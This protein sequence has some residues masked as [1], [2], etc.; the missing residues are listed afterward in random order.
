MEQ[1]QLILVSQLD[2]RLGEQGVTKLDD[3]T[4]T[5]D[6]TFELGVQPDGRRLDRAAHQREPD[7][8]VRGGPVE[9]LDASSERVE[10]RR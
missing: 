7:E 3:L 1:P 5:P 4:E 2:Q 10:Q 6:E 9:T 8:G